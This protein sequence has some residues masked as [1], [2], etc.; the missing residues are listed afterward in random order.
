MRQDLKP[1]SQPSGISPAMAILLGLVIA[2][3]AVIVF[4]L[5]THMWAWMPFGFI[6][7]CPLMMLFMMFFMMRGHA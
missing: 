2:V 4:Q 7:L 3:C 1:G 6:V 5:S